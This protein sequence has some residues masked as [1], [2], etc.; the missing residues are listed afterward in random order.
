MKKIIVIALMMSGCAGLKLKDMNK[1][2]AGMSKA[3]VVDALGEPQS[4]KMECGKEVYEYELK[5]NDGELKPRVV[6]FQDR[7]VSFYGKPSEVK[8]CKDSESE[9][10]TSNTNTN[11]NNVNP[12]ITVGAPNITFNPIVTVT[13]QS[14]TASPLLDRVP[15]NSYFHSVPTAN[16]LLQNK[17]E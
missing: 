5:D 14:T 4:K 2:G 7:E 12:V 9:S 6:V 13:P 11:T 10:S 17:G 15:A 8:K 3:Q 16:E 1:I